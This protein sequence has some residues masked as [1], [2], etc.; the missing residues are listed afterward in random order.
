M[1]PQ[2]FDFR[3]KRRI[4]P[5]GK[6]DLIPMGFKIILIELEQA[7]SYIRAVI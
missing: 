2:T 4:F 6:V 3:H 5:T 1:L 7:E